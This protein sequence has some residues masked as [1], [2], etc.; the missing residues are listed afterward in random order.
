MSLEG[1]LLALSLMLSPC[2]LPGVDTHYDRYIKSAAHNYWHPSR[3]P[4]WCILKAQA[5]AESGLNPDAVSPAGA[6]GI[7]QF[8]QGTWMD[9]QVKTGTNG[10]PFDPWIS[11]INAAAY[12]EDLARFWLSPRSE[13]CRME[14]V[15]A[16]YNAGP[17]N[18]FQAQIESRMKRC[19]NKIS[20][21]LHLVTGHHSEETI[22]YV[23]R[24]TRLFYK[25]TGH[26]ISGRNK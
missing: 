10:T 5:I 23:R 6:K 14:L 19:W 7:F 8:M 15:I 9:Y 22:E 17:G 4:Y 24:V 25:M 18:I 16:S 21:N 13:E 1:T 12:T 3:R 2:D 20:G 26:D 11:A